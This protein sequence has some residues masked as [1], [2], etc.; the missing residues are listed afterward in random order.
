MYLPSPPLGLALT[1]RSN[2]W[3]LRELG[4]GWMEPQW[5][6]M[7]L[8]KCTLPAGL[9]HDLEYRYLRDLLL[10]YCD[11][12]IGTCGY[13]DALVPL[14]L[15]TVRRYVHVRFAA[16]GQVARCPLPIAQDMCFLVFGS[17][18]VASPPVLLSQS[19]PTSGRKPWGLRYGE[20]NP[21]HSPIHPTVTTVTQSRR[22]R[23]RFR[24][25]KPPESRSQ[26]FSLGVFGPSSR[27]PRVTQ[28]P[29]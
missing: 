10:I 4:R 28:L 11:S 3:N 5:T 13:R 15:S 17:C 20:T 23:D 2:Q 21:V 18:S 8:T 27:L 9:R 19:V 1:E 29:N 7:D 12:S 6:W 25:L 22:K 24:A 14:Y 26:R 16:M